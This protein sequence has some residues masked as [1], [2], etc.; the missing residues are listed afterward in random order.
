[1]LSMQRT[2]NK[3][4][5]SAFCILWLNLRSP[6]KVGSKA[7]RCEGAC[8]RTGMPDL[9]HLTTSIKA[10]VLMLKGRV[11]P[12]GTVFARRGNGMIGLCSA[13]RDLLRK[14]RNSGTGRLIFYEIK[15]RNE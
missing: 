4:V 15:N 13:V 7:E 9:L 6:K 2:Y 3:K 1:M 11:G 12:F 14:G 10:H 5:F 8:K